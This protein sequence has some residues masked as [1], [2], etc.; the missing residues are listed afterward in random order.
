MRATDKKDGFSVQ[1]I[2]GTRAV[3]LGMNAHQDAT[4][5]LVGFG[6][7]RRSGP[8]GE[9]RW[10]NGFKTF[11]EVVPDPQRGNH[12]PTV[13]QPIQDFK[14][15]HYSA[16]PDEANHYVVRPLFKPQSG[17]LSNLRSGTDLE[18]SV[19]TEKEDS[20]EHSVLFNRGAIVSQ[21][22]SAKFDNDAG[23]DEYELA[24]ELDDPEAERTQWLSRGL[25]EAAL[26]FIGQAKS[27]RFSLHCAFYELT[28][29]PILKALADAASAGA[30]VEVA[31]EADHFKTRAQKR[32][33]S[34][35]GKR[36]RDA[37]AE[38][39]GKPRLHFRERIHHISIPH[40]KFI[41]LVE[42]GH[43]IAVWT[44]STNITSSGFLGQSNVGHIVR[45]ETVAAAYLAYFG[46]IAADA[47][48][49]ELKA[50]TAQ[51]SP[52]PVA[53][54]AGATSTLFSPRYNESML[55]WYGDRMDE[56]SQT[57]LLTSAFGVTPK[58]AEHFNNDRDYLRYILMEQE[59]RG[60]GAQKM[61]ERDKDTRIV[62]GQGLGTTGRLG[63]WKDIPGWKLEK[64]M[65]RE[66]HYRSS[67]HVFFCHTKYMVIDPL[68]DD[69]LVFSGS[70]NFSGASLKNNDENMLLI[71]GNQSVADIYTTEFFRLLNHF[72]YRQVAN[73]KAEDG[74]SDPAI[75]FLEPDDSW[76]AG[77]FSQ[78]NY[79]S[80][81]R[82]LFGIPA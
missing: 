56:A 3:H 58:L 32:V 29:P 70:A 24:A 4:R 72:Y 52:N 41:V 11:R 20:G 67:G 14:W 12:F 75:R 80:K 45:E 1:A 47:K 42:N 7:G 23:L 66:H 49:A 59:S 77:H 38:Y 21:A 28:Y 30:T 43:P 53:L 62:L 25:L 35:Q 65:W 46:Q 6:I 34:G 68:T 48:R 57:I 10:L 71:R 40:N 15:G 22:Y 50:W 63:H 51:H 74:Q 33:E 37:I 73:R 9:I 60:A 16:R 36:N 8:G 81:R 64:W 82:E 5:D 27:S 2:S 26:A 76:V 61:L 31:F 78:Q 13:E 44:G 55:D 69:P 79:R 19:R 17:D 54:A 18:V 39:K